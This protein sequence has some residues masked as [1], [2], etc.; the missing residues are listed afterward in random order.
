MKRPIFLLFF[1]ALLAFG[2]SE[3]ARIDTTTGAVTPAGVAWDLPAASTVN[4]V[5]LSALGGGTYTGLIDFSGTDHA[6]VKLINLTTA[7]RDALTP[8]EGMAIYNTTTADIEGYVS[9]AWVSLGGAGTVS[10]P[11][12]STDTKFAVWSGT[13]G[14]TLVDSTVGPTEV[15]LIANNLNDV[16]SVL[17]ARSNLG[18]GAL[19]VLN[20]VTAGEIDADAVDSSEIA[21]DAV[22][23]SELASTAVIPG[24]Y[25]YTTL[26]VDADGRIT[27]AS[28]GVAG[29]G[30]V[31]GPGSAVDGEIVLFNGTT[32]KLIKAGTGTTIAD[33]AAVATDLSQFA[34]TTS[35]QLAGVLSDETGTGAVVLANSPTLISPALG[36]P[37][38]GVATNLTGTAAGLTAGSVTTNAD[39]TG[40]ITS[41][42]N[43]AVL[44]SFTSANLS[45]ALSDETGSGSAVFATSPTFVTP[46]LG[47][48][49]SGV[50]THLTGTAAG[51]TAG[52]VTGGYETL[53]IGAG[54]M[55]PRA[56]NGGSFDSEEYAT[57]DVQQ[58]HILF[59]GSTDEAVTAQFVLPDSWDLGTVKIKFYW[60]G[61]TGMSA[62]DTVELEISGVAQADSAAID[63]AFASPVTITDD[64][65]TL[66]DRHISAASSALTIQGTPTLGCMIVL[67]ILRD[68]SVE[69]VPEDVKLAGI[70]IQWK[71]A[72]AAVS[73]W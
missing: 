37:A 30:D 6:G 26:T 46:A 23:A 15:M 66:G 19:A 42:G 33:L 29:A 11:G 59:D 54:A 69:T 2:N 7:Q 27:A 5:V 1:A 71:K 36:T 38:S 61:S 22:G 14:D 3:N 63:T 45:G 20:S 73:A 32:G 48:P 65:I 40:H 52:L 39:L 13:G 68:V 9:G 58:D 50:A 21:A 49:S 12:S 18:L 44:G 4:G 62:A 34:A 72:T 67:Q 8:S 56:T 25:N 31:V 24:T 43:A 60:D 10:G 17:T 16:Q 55:A 47:T 41:T 35:A 57:N 53:W 28:T 64:L 51:L 70:S